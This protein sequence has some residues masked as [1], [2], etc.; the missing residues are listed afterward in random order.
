M[1]LKLDEHLRWNEHVNELIIKISQALKMI[2]RV[3]SFM[4]QNNLLL[5][6]HSLIEQGLNYCSISMGHCLMV[7]SKNYKI[8]LL[9]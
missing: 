8:E 2:W 3:S 9:E 7:K 6:Y 4:S 1:G 5:I